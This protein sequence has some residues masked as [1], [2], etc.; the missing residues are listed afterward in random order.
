MKRSL[1]LP[2]AT[3]CTL[4]AMPIYGASSFSAADW[5]VD[6]AKHW[7]VSREFTMA[8]ADAM[9]AESYG[10][11]P[12]TELKPVEMSFGELMAHIAQANASNFGRITGENPPARPE[13]VDKTS[14]MK[15]LNDSFDFCAKQLD[16][17]TDEQLDKIY[18]KEPRQ[19]PGRDVLWS[20]FTHMAH[21]RG[22]AEV[23][24]RLKNIKPPGYRF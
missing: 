22:Q 4:L 13:K 2:L 1:Y 24:L 21:H 16:V 11:I 6:F 3:A 18:G 14:A 15:Y 17:M 8:V 19:M 9:P 7:A 23:Y 20:Y 5:K 10:F 12:N